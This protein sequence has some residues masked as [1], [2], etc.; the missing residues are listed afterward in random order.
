ME[1]LDIIGR[2]AERCHRYSHDNLVG[3]M[4]TSVAEA[5]R[6]EHLLHRKRL[7]ISLK[8]YLVFCLC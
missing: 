2:K 4:P 8:Y 7:S 1:S 3:V 6:W 5:S